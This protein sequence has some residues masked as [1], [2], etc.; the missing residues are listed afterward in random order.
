MGETPDNEDERKDNFLLNAAR[1]TAIA[2]TL[3]AGV[4]G[5]YAI[6]YVLDGWLHTTYLKMVFLILGIAAGFAELIRLLLRD[7]RK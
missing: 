6:G 5:G 1:Y 3:P 4:V 2:T 7:L